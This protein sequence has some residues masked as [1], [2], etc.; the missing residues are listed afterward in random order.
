[1]FLCS[2]VSH[3][4]WPIWYSANKL[5]WFTAWEICEGVSNKFP[6]QPKQRGFHK[7]KGL[8]QH[9]HGIIIWGNCFKRKFDPHDLVKLELTLLCYRK[10]MIQICSHLL[11]PC[12]VETYN[13]L[14][15]RKKPNVQ[16]Y[17]HQS[18]PLD[19]ILNQFHLPPI[20]TIY[21]HVIHLYVI[22]LSPFWSP[23]W[24][25][26]KRFPCLNS[27]CIPCLLHP[28]YCP[29]H[30]ILLHFTLL[31][32]PHDLCNSPCSSLCNILNCLLTINNTHEPA[33][34][35]VSTV[36]TFPSDFPITEFKTKSGGARESAIATAS[37]FSWEHICRI[38]SL[39]RSARVESIA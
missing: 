37:G 33:L 18:P 23:K 31:T 2:F 22:L 14:S 34:E 29:I 9:G 6:A 24:L 1:M 19:M 20:L 16:H 7:I 13:C 10:V 38:P 25:F 27:V 11:C 12:Y 28:R 8:Y 32:I 36:Q 30:H 5:T 17:Q 39:T 26:S 35:H 4:T 21:F 3:H 15:G